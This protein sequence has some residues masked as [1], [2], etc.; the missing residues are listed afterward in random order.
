MAN[1][2]IVG[3]ARKIRND[4]LDAWY[5]SP[6]EASEPG[7]EDWVRKEKE[8]VA[9]FN[10]P[11]RN[12]FFFEQGRKF[13]GKLCFIKEYGEHIL[14]AMPAIKNSHNCKYIALKLFQLAITEAR[15]RNVPHL[16]TFLDD[17]NN[18]YKILKEALIEVG[19][20]VRKHKILYG[21]SLEKP[22][23]HKVEKYITYRSVD[24]LG[25]EI[26]KELFLK[27]L[28]GSLDNTNDLFPPTPDEEF[29]VIWKS[30]HM[31]EKLGKV[32][33]YKHQPMGLVFLDIIEEK[34]GS[35]VYLAVLPELRGLGFGDL[36]FANGLDILRTIGAIK[37]LDSTSISNYPMIKIFERNGCRRIMSRMEFV[38]QK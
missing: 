32:A 8:W 4:E 15:I 35:F 6:K 26:V 21:R 3:T 27:S 33:F 12:L 36:L 7:F 38:Y 20:R 10:I 13:P 19:F 16:E 2:E 17:C 11:I 28:I 18:P 9:C 22:L 5:A 25:I 29:K 34:T 1:T 14:F 30:M 24:E 37:Y 31:R 23:K